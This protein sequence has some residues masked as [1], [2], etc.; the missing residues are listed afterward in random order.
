MNWL[1][2]ISGLFAAF[3]TV[4]HFVMGSKLYLRPMLDATFD[5]VAKKV[6]HCVFHYVSTDLVLSAIVLLAAGLGLDFGLHLRLLVK[7]I[8]IHYA[9]YAIAQIII[10]LTSRIPNPLFKMFQWTF[11]V[12]IALSAWLGAA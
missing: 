2:F 11:F 7:F 8:A 5:E 6:M 3:T 9:I 4:G 10:A 1:V 12:L